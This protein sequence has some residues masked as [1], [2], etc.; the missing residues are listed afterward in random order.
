MEDRTLCNDAPGPDSAHLPSVSPSPSS[1][2]L[3]QQLGRNDPL[4]YIIV[5]LTF[6]SLGI[7]LMLVKY[8]RTERRELE[9]EKVLEVFL[10]TKPRSCQDDRSSSSGKLALQALN[11]ASAISQPCGRAGGKITFV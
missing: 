7:I 4:L 6:Y 1:R 3:L 11:A 2:P 5:V 10:K 9:E 8:L